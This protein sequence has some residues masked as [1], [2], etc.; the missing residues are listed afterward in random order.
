MAT[1][2]GSI[3]INTKINEKGFN[4]GI[5][6]MMGSLKGLAAA[7]GI[8]FGVTAIVNFGKSAVSAASEMSSAYIGL[9]SIVEGQGK[10]FSGAKSFIQ[11]YIADGLVPAT[12][13]VTA[14]KNLLL[15]G[16]DTGQIES[17]MNALKN[18][19]A[20]GRQSSLTMGQAVQSATEGLKNE[21][22][23]LVD[24]SGVT[25]NVSVM[26]KEYADSIGVGVQ[27]LTKSQKIIAETNGILEETKYQMGDAAKLSGSYSGKVSALGVSFTNLKVAVGNSII[28]IINQI[29]PYIKSAIDTLVI[30]FNKVAD[31]MNAFFGTKISMADTADAASSIADSTDAAATAQDNLADSTTAAGKAAKGALA[32]FDELNVL[33]QDTST[34]DAGSTGASSG[35]TASVSVDTSSATTGLTDLEKKVAA[36]KEKFLAFIQPTIDAFDRLKTALI[37]LGETIWSGLKWAWDNILVP[38]G[39]WVAGKAVPA[40]LDLLAAE[41]TILNSALIALKPFAQWL[42]DNFLK[43]LA[44]WTG[45]EIIYYLNS[46]TDAFLKLS[47]WINNNQGSLSTMTT[48]IDAFFGSFI[49]DTPWFITNV[50]SPLK[51]AFSELGDSFKELIN[52]ID[53]SGAALITFFMTNFW[54]SLK[55]VIDWL[56]NYFSNGINIVW[57]LIQWA[58]S[59]IG[60]GITIGAD[61]IVS[62][63]KIL[64]T[65]ISGVVSGI[66]T[67]VSGIYE[68]I[69]GVFTLNWKLA[70]TGAVNVFRGI[71][72]IIISIVNGMVNGVISGIN[73]V[74][75]ALNT[76][77]VN[78]PSWVPGV[79]GQSYGVNLGHVSGIQIPYL[80]Q[81][82]VIPPNAAFAAVL[83]DQKSGV[84]IESPLSTMVE[85]FKAA[86]IDIGGDISITTPVYL[87]SE[88][89]Y[90]GQ[91]KVSKRR[92]TSLVGA[93]S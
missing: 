58:I 25:K 5:S 86:A 59:V 7:V 20:F 17:T 50:I 60:T 33:A 12:N 38:F 32:S 23:I 67:A 4:S 65:S 83:G 87:D 61:Y 31:I 26:W 44:V 68:F 74:I 66:I 92:G 90:E 16:Y 14:Y 79:G 2:D 39:S 21:N 46:L 30:F 56:T 37:P 80:A 71:A 27:S 15:R 88:K 11:S 3:N 28:P 10:S 47:D 77:H 76:V 42:W 6:S 82:A 84:N 13:A 9:Q 53:I 40:F 51:S 70:W 43:P 55:I 36:F 69:A 81:G 85:A 63:F 8:A 41:V 78:I 22:S 57:G 73:A 49:F 75:S 91:Q 62:V 64:L 34:K 19:S 52:A 93:T 45:G 35:S 1:Y 48:V 18:A 54:P 29:L 24:N 89:I 72:N